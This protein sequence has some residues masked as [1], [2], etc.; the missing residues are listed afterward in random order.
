MRIGKAKKREKACPR[1]RIHGRPVSFFYSQHILIHQVFLLRRSTA[2]P[3]ALDWTPC[4][5]IPCPILS[6]RSV[7]WCAATVVAF[8]G[9]IGGVPA[10]TFSLCLSFCVEMG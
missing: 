3:P 1:A 2:N 9:P 7:G 4:P 8:P 5:R 6:P 10:E